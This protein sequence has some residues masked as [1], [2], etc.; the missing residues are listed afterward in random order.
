MLRKARGWLEQRSP[1][2]VISGYY[3]LAV[4]VSI[5]LFSIPAVHKPGVDVSFFDTVFT[6][7]SVVS[8][9]GLGV[10]NVSETY[11]VFGYFVIILVLQFGGIGIMA[12]STFFWMLLGRKI[13]LKERQ[14]IMVDN[15]QFELSGL[16]QLVKEIL[17]IIVFAELIGGLILGFYYLRFFSTWEEAFLQGLFASVSATTNA[18]MDITGNSLI[19]F[20]G[21][22]FVQLVTITLIIFG[23]IGFPVL[24]EVKNYFYR[25]RNKSDSPFRFSLFTK[26]TTFTYAI[27]LLMGTIFILLFEYQHYFK[28]MTWHESF[29]YAFFQAATTR[30]AGLTTMDI[31]DFSMPTHLFMSFLM[32][33]GGSPNS[34]GGGIRTTTFALNILFIYHF[35]RGNRDIKV[36]NRELHPDD[37]MKSLAITLLAIIMCGM[38]VIAISISD[39]EQQLIAILLEVCSA[40]GTVGLSTGI[41]PEL[42]PFARCLLMI[43]MFIGRIGLTSFLF[44]IGG[45]QKKAKFNYP[46]ERVI[47]G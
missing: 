14:L 18:G 3:L 2:Q 46:K 44:I 13:G 28:G 16:V 30:S 47:T 45:R 9:T 33:I 11:S 15:N 40:F 22:Y 5:L 7:V 27:L 20:A 19:P 10:F 37:V 36:F 34:V 35:A 1:A 8:D 24:V 6:A 32:F 43:L 4:I 29:F 25:R 23:T 21:D 17:K 12:M 41:T 39:S 42:S 26:L 38:S 31:N